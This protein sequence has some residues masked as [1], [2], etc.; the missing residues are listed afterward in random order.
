MSP[1]YQFVVRTR[2]V[3]K[4][5]MAGVWSAGYLGYMV[6]ALTTPTADRVEEFVGMA[7]GI[8]GLA[9]LTMSIVCPRCR[10][11]IVVHVLRTALIERM[12][13]ELAAM[14]SCPYC[15]YQPSSPARDGQ[16]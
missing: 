15:R 14:A 9:L 8:L 6:R 1:Q 3:W 2:Q 5:G 7:I 4:F 11:R 13:A 12:V 16:D 10:G